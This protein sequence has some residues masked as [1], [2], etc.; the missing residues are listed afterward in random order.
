MTRTYLGLWM[1]C[2]KHSKG[3]EYRKKAIFYGRTLSDLRLCSLVYFFFFS[4]PV[5]SRPQLLY[6][7]LVF[8]LSHIVVPLAHLPLLSLS[9]SLLFVR[10]LHFFY[11]IYLFFLVSCVSLLP[12]TL[13]M[14]PLVNFLSFPGSQQSDHPSLP[15]GTPPCITSS[16]RRTSI[17]PCMRYVAY[18]PFFCCNASSLLLL[19]ESPCFGCR[20]I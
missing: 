16:V 19:L 12:F 14:V 13:S 18:P 2:W 1:A 10:F 8:P 4:C 3:K 11:S 5:F 7:Y 9:L 17:Y 6:S 15:V 20:A